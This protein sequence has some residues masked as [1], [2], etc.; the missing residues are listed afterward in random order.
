MRVEPPNLQLEG[1]S[2]DHSA[3]CSI[4]KRKESDR[5]TQTRHTHDSLVLGEH[6]LSTD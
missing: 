4:G 5:K 6:K 3:P 2:A 1:G